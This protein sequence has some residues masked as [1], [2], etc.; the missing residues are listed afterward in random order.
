MTVSDQASSLAAQVHAQQ[1]RGRWQ[2]FRGP[3]RWWP[4]RRNADCSKLQI[5][6]R[7]CHCH[8]PGPG[9]DHTRRRR[10]DLRILRLEHQ[11]PR[12]MPGTLSAGTSRSASPPRKRRAKRQSFH[13]PLTRRVELRFS[14][15]Y[16]PPSS[17]TGGAF[18]L[19]GGT[20]CRK[21]SRFSWT[22]RTFTSR[23]TASTAVEASRTGACQTGS[24]GRPDRSP[25]T[26]AQHGYSGLR[27]SEGAP[28]PITSRSP[29]RPTMRRASQWERDSRVKVSAGQ[30]NYRG[31]PASH[32]R[33]RAST[34]RSPWTLIRGLQPRLRR[35][36]PVLKRYRP[37]ARP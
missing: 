4:H 16:S 10:E 24:P 3:A 36:G 33:R 35:T 9:H 18:L 30:L 29:L 8:R 1:A 37:T 6:A 14:N 7:P 5:P 17:G 19:P 31:W 11:V 25:P 23:G 20:K 2:A 26:Q 28:I 13:P 34:S 32:R 21:T 15:H 12:S 27:L 22:F